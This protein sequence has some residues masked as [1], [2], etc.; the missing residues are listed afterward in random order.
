M[1][2][3][4][5]AAAWRRRYGRQVV[6]PSNEAADEDGAPPF[7]ADALDDVDVDV[8]SA[9]GGA[10]DAGAEPDFARRPQVSVE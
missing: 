4:H 3:F 7:R 1:T 5:A 6:G 10:D 8:V 9:E 2:L